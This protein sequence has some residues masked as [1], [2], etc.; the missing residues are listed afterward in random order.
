MPFN[1][2]PTDPEFKDI[3]ATLNKAG[4]ATKNPP[5]H[6]A[7]KTIIDR[8]QKWRANVVSNFSTITNNI[9]N[10]NDTISNSGGSGG[11]QADIDKLKAADYAT[12]A[13]DHTL[14]PNSRQLIAGTNITFDDSI[15]NQRKI[16]AT[17]GVDYVVMSDGS[18][19]TAHTVDDGAGN[20]IYVAY[21]P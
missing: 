4:L 21:T 7:V 8:L 18:I 13:D 15:A 10:I 19:P 14:L 6:Q 2:A 12:V 9:A 20:F 1:P 3:I 16:S 11:L 17:A 5:L